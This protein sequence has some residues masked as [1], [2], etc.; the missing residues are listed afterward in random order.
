MK[1]ADDAGQVFNLVYCSLTTANVS[2]GYGKHADTLDQKSLETAILQNTICFVFGILAFSLPK[3]AVAALL[4]RLL[5]PSLAQ[6]IW[7]W[8]LTGFAFAVSIVCIILLFVLCDPP[9][10]V[11]QVHLVTEGAATCKSTWTLV[12]YTIFTGGEF[13]ARV[14]HGATSNLPIKQSLRSLTYTWLSILQLC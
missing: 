9:K 5:N 2:I 12:D 1:G 8:S 7:L 14:I 13:L 11:W 10:A 6:R 3:L 4:N